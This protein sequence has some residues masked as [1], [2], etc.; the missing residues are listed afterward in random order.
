MVIYRSQSLCLIVTNDNWLAGETVL[1][2]QLQWNDFINYNLAA[3]M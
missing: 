3:T 1:A 2:L